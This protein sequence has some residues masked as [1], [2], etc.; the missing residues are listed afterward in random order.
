MLKKIAVNVELHTS[1]ESEGVNTTKFENLDLKEDELV[2]EIQIPAKLQNLAIQLQGEVS[3]KEK[4]H[5]VEVG[6]LR[7][8]ELF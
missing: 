5:K 3:G 4:T 1:G 7:N 2:V 6:F 8:I